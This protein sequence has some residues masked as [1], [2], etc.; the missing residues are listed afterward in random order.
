[1]ARPAPAAGA[2]RSRRLPHLGSRATYLVY[3]TD[4]EDVVLIDY[5]PLRQR[6]PWV[7]LVNTGEQDLSGHYREMTAEAPRGRAIVERREDDLVVLRRGWD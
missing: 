2:P 1:M 4:V 3:G 6:F 5:E 7:G